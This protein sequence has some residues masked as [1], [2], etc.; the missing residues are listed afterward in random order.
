MSSNA[1]PDT[2]C[3]FRPITIGNLKLSHHIVLLP[4]TRYSA[5]RLT[6]VPINPMLKTYYEQCASVP[7]TLLIT[8]ATLITAKADGE[9]NIPGVWN[10]EQIDTWN[11]VTNAV[12]AKGPDIFTQIW[13]LG[14]MA[15]IS[16]LQEETL[17]LPYT[18]PSPNP[19]SHR[20]S[21]THEL[22]IPK[23]EECITLFIR[24]AKNTVEARFNGVEIDNANGWFV[25]SVCE[26]CS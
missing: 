22:A 1:S 10:Q 7:G 24:A 25:G 21:T 23:I 6:H 2:S 9:H 18:T 17:S 19:L 16:H 20:N 26:G 15:R 5:T 4:L 13:A 12:H 3:L 14:R 8:G 11:E